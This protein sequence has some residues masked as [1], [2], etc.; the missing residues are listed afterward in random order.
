[1]QLPTLTK[2]KLIGVRVGSNDDVGDHIVEQS[3]EAA[4]LSDPSIAF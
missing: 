4:K 3:P 1:M 2:A